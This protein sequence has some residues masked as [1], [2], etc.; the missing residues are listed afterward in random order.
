MYSDREK[1]S[2]RLMWPRI[3]VHIAVNTFVW[4]PNAL[5]RPKLYKSITE[6]VNHMM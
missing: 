2:E 3:V 5:H 4:P 1:L 6:S